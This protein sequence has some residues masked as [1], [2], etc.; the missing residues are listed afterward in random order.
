V[1]W[2]RKADGYWAMGDAIVLRIV[3]RFPSAVCD[4]IG[5]ALTTKI[6]QEL[7]EIENIEPVSDIPLYVRWLAEESLTIE[8]HRNAIYK[9]WGQ[10]VDDF[11][12]IADFKDEV[13]LWRASVPERP[14]SIRPF[15]A[16]ELR[17][18]IVKIGP[19][20]FGQRARLPRRGAS[21]GAEG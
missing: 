2:H 6:G 15:A 8:K 10:V 3:N 13:G 4:E 7:Q 12:A 16:F 21:T 18:V 20:F 11:L 1:N 5:V 9:V 19:P 14:T 17:K